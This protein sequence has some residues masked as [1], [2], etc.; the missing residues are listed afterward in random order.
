MS[1][2]PAR[3]CRGPRADVPGR[4]WNLGPRKATTRGASPTT[5]DPTL[6]PNHRQNTPLCR[7]HAHG[8]RRDHPL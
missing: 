4:A 5:S 3:H 6:G 8:R 7:L 1:A 2:R